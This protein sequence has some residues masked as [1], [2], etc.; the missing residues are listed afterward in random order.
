MHGHGLLLTLLPDPVADKHVGYGIAELLAMPPC[1]EAEHHVHWHRASGAGHAFTLDRKQA[2]VGLNPGKVF[3]HGFQA[4]P[5][6]T[7]GVA[8]EQTG[9]GQHIGAGTDRSQQ[10]MLP[11]HLFQPVRFLA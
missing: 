8:V 3:L 9:T 4:F 11:G 2:V 7:A 1:Q 5:V 6:G 10:D